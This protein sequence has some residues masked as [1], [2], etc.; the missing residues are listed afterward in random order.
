MDTGETSLNAEATSLALVVGT[1]QPPVASPASVSA[2]EDGPVI[3]GQLVAIDPDGDPLTF[4]PVL[5]A[6]FAPGIGSLVINRDGSFSLD[7]SDPFFQSL[8]EGETGEFLAGFFVSDGNLTDS[9]T[10]TITVTGANDAP[11]FDPSILEFATTAGTPAG[12]AI[13][14]SDIDGDSL[15]YSAADPDHGSITGGTDGQFTYTPAPGYL[16]IDVVSVTVSDGHGGSDTKHLVVTVNFPSASDWTLLAGDGFAGEIGGTGEVFGASGFQDIS[17]RNIAGAISLDGSFNAGNDIVRLPGA[18]EGWQVMR[19]ASAAIF[20]DGDTFVRIPVGIEGMDVAFGDGVRTLRYDDTDGSF[21]IGGQ[22]FGLDLVPVSAPAELSLPPEEADPNAVGRLLLKPGAD[23]SAGGKLEIFGTSSAEQIT[24]THG[25]AL[26]DPSFNRG[27]D[28]L[29][30]NEPANSFTAVAVGSAIELS[31]AQT[32][33]TIPVGTSGM[34]LSF[35]DG[36][37][38]AL[39]YDTQLA[40]I[41]VGAQEIGPIPIMLTDFA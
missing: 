25:E 28:T 34:T 24:L 5:T 4:S 37:D 41:L 9:S 14:A 35:P 39:V 6:Q 27:G 31:G 11:V 15:T 17:I 22:S 33:V 3:T 38:R 13:T 10:L 7:P 40:S 19:S 26:L 8:A 32:T 20:T 12:F 2:I 16:G 30:L 23:L 36:D 29:V 1:N 21:R 18:A